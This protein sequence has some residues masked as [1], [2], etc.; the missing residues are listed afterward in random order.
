MR[1]LRWAAQRLHSWMAVRRLLRS[2][3]RQKHRGWPVRRRLQYRRAGAAHIGDCGVERGGRVLMQQ[4]RSRKRMPVWKGDGGE[5]C[6]CRCC[7][8]CCCCCC[9]RCLREPL[10]L[11]FQLVPMTEIR[12]E[13][14]LLQVNDVR[15][16]NAGSRWVR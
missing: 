5:I 10:L 15:C 1:G 2:R 9:C 7:R 16:S 13:L 14:L 6:C 3:R 8:C 12:S 4:P 11:L